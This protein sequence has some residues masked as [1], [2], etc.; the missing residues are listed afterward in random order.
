MKTI[1]RFMTRFELNREVSYALKRDKAW[2]QL[3]ADTFKKRFAMTKAGYCPE[4]PKQGF[5][6]KLLN[7]FNFNYWKFD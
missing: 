3:Q 2:R 5:F 6:K 7:K 1:R 4:V